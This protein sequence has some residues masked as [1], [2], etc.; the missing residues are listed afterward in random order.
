[1]VAVLLIVSTK[2]SLP[3]NT[4]LHLFGSWLF[5][6]AVWT[7]QDSEGFSSVKGVHGSTTVMS[8]V[9]DLTSPPDSTSAVPSAG[10]QQHRL[11]EYEAGRADAFEAL[12][13]VFSS[14]ECGEEIL[15]IYLARFYHSMAVG[16]Q[17]NSKVRMSVWVLKW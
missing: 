5:E 15:P 8:S 3:G 13:S 6:A 16:L 1:M 14:R 17:Y 10:Y 2:I 11:R 12:C 4:L 9:A 7:G